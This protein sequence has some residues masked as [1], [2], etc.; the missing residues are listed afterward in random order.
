MPIYPNILGTFVDAGTNNP[1]DVTFSSVVIAAGKASDLEVQLTQ[2]GQE[3]LFDAVGL[4][5]CDSTWC[6][7]APDEDF[8]RITVPEIC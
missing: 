4:P 5:Q 6:H 1:F 3:D 7:S 8:N 2:Q